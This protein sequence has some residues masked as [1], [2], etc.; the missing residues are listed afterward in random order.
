MSLLLLLA[1][2]LT[3]FIRLMNIDALKAACKVPTCSLT[4]DISLCV[5]AS[6]EL[7]V[8]IKE[9]NEN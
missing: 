8:N 1:I 7:H 3:L 6:Y 5:N 2:P 4:C 9:L